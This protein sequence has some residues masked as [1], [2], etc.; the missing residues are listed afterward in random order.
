MLA[1]HQSQ[2]SESVVLVIKT[3]VKTAKWNPVEP[4]VPIRY[5]QQQRSFLHDYLLCEVPFLH[6][7]SSLVLMWSIPLVIAATVG[8]VLPFLLIGK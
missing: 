5:G 3:H 2:L 7:K 1:I 6:S 8:V 4:F